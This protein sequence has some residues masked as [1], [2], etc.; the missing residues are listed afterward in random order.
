MIH[1]FP[2]LSHSA[3]LKWHCNV[4]TLASLQDKGWMHF[5][6]NK[7]HSRPAAFGLCNQG[8]ARGPVCGAEWCLPTSR[9]TYSKLHKGMSKMDLGPQS[10]SGY[11]NHEH[12]VPELVTK[13]G[14][15]VGHAHCDV[16]PLAS[17]GQG[18]EKW[19][20]NKVHSRPAAFG[21]CKQGRVGGARQKG[22]ETRIKS[23]S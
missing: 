21:L 19:L 20:Q 9:G 5:L 17:Q 6:W 16:R 7:M 11:S 10:L 22:D 8:C 2:N 23:S 3:V 18:A 13:C 15:K 14:P 12:W 4:R 1:R